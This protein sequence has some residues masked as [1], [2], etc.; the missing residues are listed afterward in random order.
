M[1]YGEIICRSYPSNIE[2]FAGINEKRG[3][4]LL[5]ECT[6]DVPVLGYTNGKDLGLHF[7]GL[8][9]RG[10]IAFIKRYSF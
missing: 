3:R 9:R 6:G 1:K 2:I 10:K 8:S 7:N 5:L 4:V